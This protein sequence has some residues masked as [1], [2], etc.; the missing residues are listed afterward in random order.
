[1]RKKKHEETDVDPM[2]QEP[3]MQTDGE[4]TASGK[5]MAGSDQ[6]ARLTEER[7]GLKDQLLRT[8]ADFQNFRKRVQQERQQE[9]LY[10]S[11]QIVMQLL[12]V[13]DNF[14]RAIAAF[15]S[16][17][18]P[19]SLLEGIRAIDRQ[20]RAVLESNQVSRIPAQGNHFDPMFH[21]AI[22][23]EESTEHEPGVVLEEL[24]A[25]YRI[26]EKVIRPARVKV[27]TRS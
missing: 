4:T 27:A 10:A 24:E 22:A 13:L 15:E 16:G 20:L 25:G 11:E 7:D 17:A 19:D 12:P 3:V 21:E 2:H 9:R 1:M 8:M 14:E 18:S 5:G 6:V 23:L 26:G